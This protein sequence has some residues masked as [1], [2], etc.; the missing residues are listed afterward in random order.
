MSDTV[1]QI[2]LR[3]AVVGAV[4]GLLL[5][6]VGTLIPFGI[7]RW[8]VIGVG[9]LFVGVM[10]AYTLA[11]LWNKFSPRIRLVLMTARGHI[12]KDPLLG[13]L[14]RDV[15]ARCWVATLR[16][17]NRTVDVVI[18]G[19]DEPTPSLVARARGLVAEFETLD[20]RL[21]DFLARESKEAALESC[22]EAAEIAAL[23]VSAI[24]LRSPDHPGHVVIDLEGPDEMRYW[25]CD[26]IDGD[27]SGLRFDT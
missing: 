18:E 15:P 10:T 21:S 20:R 3:Y 7:V 1:D 4:I 26:Y 6:F 24:N 22:E 9:L 25:H 11:V 16:R 13:T 5:I 14:I 23:R 2:E 19:G 27:I 17:E 12:R 8:P